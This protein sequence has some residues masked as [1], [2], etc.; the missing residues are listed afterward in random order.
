MVRYIP[1]KAIYISEYCVLV[2]HSLIHNE[3]SLITVIHRFIHNIHS[4]YVHKTGVL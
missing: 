1:S 4:I 2:S 3:K